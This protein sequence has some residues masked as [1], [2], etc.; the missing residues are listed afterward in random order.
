MIMRRK[1]RRKAS[2]HKMVPL[3][4]SMMIK[5]HRRVNLRMRMKESRKTLGLL[6]QM[7]K[8][9]RMKRI[10]MKKMKMNKTIALTTMKKN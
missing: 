2:D 1:K 7:R 9:T 6:K 4:R 5:V 10:T 3:M 8:K